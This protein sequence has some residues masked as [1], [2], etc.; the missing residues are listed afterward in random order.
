MASRP[1]GHNQKSSSRNMKYDG[2]KSYANRIIE[3]IS[4]VCL[5]TRHDGT[6][7]LMNSLAGG[8]SKSS[9]VSLASFSTKM[10]SGLCDSLDCA[11][12]NAEC[13]APFLT[14]NTH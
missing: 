3:T 12:P 8:S 11:L 10:N 2:D 7:G 13:L 6:S 14:I 1:E 9:A 5:R 4:L